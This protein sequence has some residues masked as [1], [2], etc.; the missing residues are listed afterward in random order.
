MCQC[1]EEV[2]TMSLLWSSTHDA[3][4]VLIFCKTYWKQRFN[5]EVKLHGGLDYIH[6]DISHWYALY[7]RSVHFVVG[8]KDR[9]TDFV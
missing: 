2:T 3:D 1:C 5:Y 4:G 6:D 9:R 8:L 7:C